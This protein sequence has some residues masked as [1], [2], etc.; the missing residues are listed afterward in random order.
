M[1]GFLCYKGEDSMNHYFTNSNIK[2][3]LKTHKISIKD[4]SFNFYTDNGVFSKKKLDY[5]TRLLIESVISE[6]ISGNAL[7][8]GCGYGVIGVVLSSFLDLKFDFIDVN[9]RALHLAD[10]NMKENKIEGN[11]FYSNVYENVSGKYDVIIS[12]PPIRAGKEI[13]YKILFDAKK[14]LNKDGVLYFVINKNQGAKSTISD[15]NKVASINILKKDKGF[16][17]IKCNFD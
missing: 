14:H 1:I 7:D 8:V 10:M 2:S 5:G 17:V 6:E 16:F 15:L 13:V 9:R 4:K 11:A 12:N 3:N